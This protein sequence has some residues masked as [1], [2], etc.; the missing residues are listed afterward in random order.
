MLRIFL[1]ISATVLLISCS[2]NGEA[3]VQ[4]RYT[5]LGIRALTVDAL[6]L[7]VEVDD[8]VIA[9]PMIAP[10]YNA[11]PATKYIDPMHRIRMT[12][13]YSNRLVLDTIVPYSKGLQTTLSFVQKG[14]DSSMVWVGP[15]VNEPAPP[16]G[17]IKVSVVYVYAGYPDEVKV[18]VENS[19]SGTSGFDYAP[20]DSFLLKKG[21]FSPYFQG[22][23]GA[24]GK[25]PRLKIFTPDAARTPIAS[26]GENLFSN[27]STDITIFSFE[28][29][30]STGLT[31]TKLY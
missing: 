15:P 12:D 28:Q 31:L 16:P 17:K 30:P 6:L 19:R 11:F 21:Q 25:K 13:L 8:S 1:F 2:K 27:I 5:N 10:F 22:W 4:E 9:A 18:V 7:K 29:A 14:Y 26:Y 3:I 23:A 24:T 20:S